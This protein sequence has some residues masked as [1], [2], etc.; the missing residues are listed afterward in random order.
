MTDKASVGL[1]IPSGGGLN[2]HSGT[3][4]GIGQ[5]VHQHERS[6]LSI[7]VVRVEQELSVGTDGAPGNVIKP[8]GRCRPLG[9]RIDVDPVTDGGHRR[10]ALTGGRPQKVL[11]AGFHWLGVHPHNGGVD[12]MCPVG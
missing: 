10:I 4:R 11:P 2:D 1:P 6:C 3:H 5:P 8:Q 7:R 12:L 9:Q